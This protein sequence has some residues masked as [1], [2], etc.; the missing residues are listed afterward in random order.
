MSFRDRAKEAWSPFPEQIEEEWL[1]IGLIAAV[2]LFKAGGQSLGGC[3]ILWHAPSQ[4]TLHQLQLS[5]MAPLSQLGKHLQKSFISFLSWHHSPNTGN[6]RLQNRSTLC[7]H[8]ILTTWETVKHLLYHPSFC[9]GNILVLGKH[10]QNHSA[11]YDT[12]LATWEPHVES[13]NFLSW[14]HSSTWETPAESFSFL[15][16]H[17]SCNLGTTCGII[18]RPVIA[19]FLLLRKY[20]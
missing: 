13:S 17:H 15:S 4:V 7:H 20:M 11:F 18:Q 12:I 9:H 6:K 2:N 19:P 14:H 16:W 1:P 8:I 10:L 5:V 3:C